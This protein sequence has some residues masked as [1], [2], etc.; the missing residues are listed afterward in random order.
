MPQGFK[1]AY[2]MS[3][4]PKLTETF[5]L[6][7]ILAVE[8]QGVEVELFPL[9][10][11]HTQTMH[12]E[13]RPL[14]QRAQF[15]PFLSPAIILSN[16]RALLTRPRA[17]LGA[18]GTSLRATWSSPRYLGGILVFF[19]KAV[20]IARLMKQQNIRHIHA[21]FA[22]HPA[23][24]A[25]IIHRL[26]GIP[27]SFTAHGSD[28]HRDQH[29]LCEKVREAAFTV[30]ISGYNAQMIRERCGAAVDR[31]MVLHSGADTSVF[32][33][34][35]ETRPAGPLNILCIGTLHEVKGQTH[36][37]EACRL[38]HERGIAFSC[39]LLG[40]GEDREKLEQ[41]VAAAHLGD[42][43]H[44]HGQVPRTEVLAALRR[45]D[46]LVTPSVPTRDGRR[47]GIPVVIMEAMAS[48]LPVVASRLSGIPELVD[49][50]VTGI[51]TEP[52]DSRAV[53]DALAR[54]ADQPDL[55]R[56]YGSA[57][58]EKVVRSFDLKQNA[59][60]LVQLFRGETE[61]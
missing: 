53:A 33:A 20:H 50:G 52:G 26:T 39:H 2:M 29:M 40:S 47:E 59:A 8:A 12:D 4:F 30:T 46:V 24:A 28:L 45:A 32:Q 61:K 9:M 16:L 37:I 57:G 60:R 15:T 18:L 17:Y 11:E 54:L 36:L 38:L 19:P 1:V 10:R 21:H 44:F 13:A 34:A 5:V 22:S 49:D 27:Y 55:R 14:V 6:Y 3:R 48:G 56:Q 43:V 35:D 42:Q 41:Q 23:A 25:F 58:R 51:L 31:V 7:E